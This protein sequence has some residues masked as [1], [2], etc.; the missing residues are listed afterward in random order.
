MGFGQP[1]F[2][3]LSVATV[4][5]LLTNGGLAIIDQSRN[6]TEPIRITKI[7]NYTDFKNVLTLIVV[8]NLT[9]INIYITTFLTLGSVRAE[10]KSLMRSKIN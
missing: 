4:D 3:I 1:R 10:E 9:R 5:N 2:V 6:W 8:I 7:I